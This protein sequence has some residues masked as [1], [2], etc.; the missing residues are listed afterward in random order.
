M[1]GNNL[2]LN[3]ALRGHLA[4]CQGSWG[5]LPSWPVAVGGRAAHRATRSPRRFLRAGGFWGQVPGLQASC[6][7]QRQGLRCLRALHGPKSQP[8]PASPC[9]PPSLLMCWT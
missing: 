3:S 9:S 7:L 8:C 1:H 5:P 6:P 4:A 2:P